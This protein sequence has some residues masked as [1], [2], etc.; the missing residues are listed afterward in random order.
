MAKIGYLAVGIL[1]A[2]EE[3]V[4]EDVPERLE[5]ILDADLLALLVGA[6]VVGDGHLVG[7]TAQLGD[8]GGH[9]H[10]K[11]EALGGDDS[12]YG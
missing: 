7:A 4:L 11:T 6:S 8:L 12:Y 9:L 2:G 10:L 3:V 1:Q 5:T